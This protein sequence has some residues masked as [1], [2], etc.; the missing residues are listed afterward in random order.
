MT[1]IM[2]SDFLTS[3][4]L[5]RDS[6]VF[7]KVAMID[8]RYFARNKLSRILFHKK[9]C[10]L[11]WQV[12]FKLKYLFCQEV[13]IVIIFWGFLIFKQIF[14]SPQVK[15]RVIIGIKHGMYE[16]PHELSNDL[17]L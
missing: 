15:R 17:R 4:N 11:I 16:L 10:S 2:L 9:N 13:S 14:F 6:K 7:L 5:N 3:S 1:V 8:I 12:V